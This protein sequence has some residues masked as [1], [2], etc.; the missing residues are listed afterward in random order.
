MFTIY[1]NITAKTHALPTDSPAF[2]GR[3]FV[4][5]PSNPTSA[6]KTLGSIGNATTATIGFFGVA[7]ETPQIK[8]SNEWGPG[9]ASTFVEK[10]EEF[11]SHKIVKTFGSA[12][13]DYRPVIGTD[14]WTQQIPQKG[15]VIEVP[16]KF[17]SYPMTAYKTMNYF[18]AIWQLYFYTT[19]KPFQFSDGLNI[20]TQ[21]MEQAAKIGFDFGNAITKLNDAV[22]VLQQAKSSISDDM[23]WND[24]INYVGENN[25][26][27]GVQDILDKTKASIPGSDDLSH[28]KLQAT[29]SIE[30]MKYLL[31]TMTA[32][33]GSGCETF[34][35]Y[36]GNLFKTSYKDW[37]ISNWSFKPAVYTTNYNDRIVPLYMD[38]SITLRTA[39]QVGT[40]DF[41]NLF[42]YDS[43]HVEPIEMEYD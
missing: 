31:N 39:G 22:K 40:R 32:P 7:E 34:T 26:Y 14:S 10:Y 28:A 43:V 4:I 9:P 20:I 1:D 2:T 13:R 15:S 3:N 30:V 8:Y 29:R 16:I 42:N 21:A 37:I 41:A 35:L 11:M 19:P 25:S 27:S 6:L 36:Y 12:N 17:R 24:I 33:E 18:R 38:I 23:K 5:Q